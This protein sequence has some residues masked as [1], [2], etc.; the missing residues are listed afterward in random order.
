MSVLIERLAIIGV[1]LIGGS[2]ARALRDT[3]MGLVQAFPSE[4]GRLEVAKMVTSGTAQ[5]Q[6]GTI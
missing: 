4:R 3:A 5:A 6:F 1:G 2:F